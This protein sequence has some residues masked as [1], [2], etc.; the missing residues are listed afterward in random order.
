MGWSEVEEGVC[1][2]A[3]PSGYVDAPENASIEVYSVD[4]RMITS[5][6]ANSTS[7]NNLVRQIDTYNL[8]TGVYVVNIT[9]PTETQSLKFVK[10]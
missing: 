8:T 2:D 10:E 7:E 1:W 9:T 3:N 4:G 5:I 6:P